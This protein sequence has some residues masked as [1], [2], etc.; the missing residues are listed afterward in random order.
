MKRTA[1]LFWIVLAAA[2][3]GAT[4]ARAQFGIGVGIAA[5]GDNIGQAGGELRDLLNKDSISY[6]DVSGDIGFYVSGR[7]RFEVGIFRILGDISYIYFQAPEVTLT[8]VGFNAADS[9]VAATFEVGTSM[10]PI[11]I[12]GAVALPLPVVKPYLGAH[13]GYTFVNR[14][15]TFIRGNGELERLDLSNKSA[16]DPEMGIAFSGGVEIGLGFATLD[17]GARYNLAN[18]FTTSDGEQSM[19]YLQVGAS[20]LLG[21]GAAD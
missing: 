6:G 12:G 1:T 8:D 4:S 16:G 20:L 3:C 21:G 19:R 7:A 5:A 11:Q 14:T 15:Y 10:I 9:T 13:L 18:L 17:V 2:V